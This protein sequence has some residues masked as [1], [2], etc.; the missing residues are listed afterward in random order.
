MIYAV[1]ALAIIQLAFI[2]YC[3]KHIK[4]IIK[5]LNSI[6]KEQHEQ[7][8]DIIRLMKTDVELTKVVDNHATALSQLV[9]VT[10]YLLNIMDKGKL[11]T[12]KPVFKSPKGD[13]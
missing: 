11:S 6:D 13:A 8:M 1:L 5:E 9:P 10:E 4:L 7:N 3:I 2:V 12:D